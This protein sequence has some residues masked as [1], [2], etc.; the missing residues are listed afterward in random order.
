MA[1][2]LTIPLA[3]SILLGATGAAAQQ[4]GAKPQPTIGSDVVSKVR[5]REGVL[6]K[7][8]QRMLVLELSR[9]ER[10]L[11]VTPKNAPERPQLLKRLAEGYAELAALAA[12]DRAIA[13]EKLRREP[14]T[15]K[16]AR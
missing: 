10:L 5:A 1:L 16:K 12:Q 2:K 9:L 6:A 8:S 14:A 3:V 4:R 15:S 11:A 13:E 7:R